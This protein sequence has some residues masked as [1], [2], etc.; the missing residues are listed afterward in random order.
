MLKNIRVYFITIR[1]N[2]PCKIEKFEF[3]VVV[4]VFQGQN[5]AFRTA[6]NRVTLILFSTFSKFENLFYFSQ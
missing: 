3:E 1:A 2:F 6:I 5:V 4:W